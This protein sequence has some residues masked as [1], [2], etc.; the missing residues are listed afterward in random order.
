MVRAVSFY[1]NECWGVRAEVETLYEEFGTALGELYIDD[2][3]WAH[4]EKTV[5]LV[6]LVEDPAMLRRLRNHLRTCRRLQTTTCSLTKEG[7]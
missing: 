2:E 6:K 5:R 7:W 1:T 4:L 3:V